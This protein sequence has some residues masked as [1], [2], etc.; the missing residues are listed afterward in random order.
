MKSVLNNII[1]FFVIGII[2]LILIP[3]PTFVLDF[4]F[5]V[6]ITISLLVLVMTMYIKGPLDF[7]I[8]PSLLL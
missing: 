6:S 1:V 7:S 8:F 3:L 4:M 2:A 5:I